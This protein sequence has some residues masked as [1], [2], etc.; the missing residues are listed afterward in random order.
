MTDFLDGLLL[1]IAIACITTA[2]SITIGFELG[3]K[4]AVEMARKKFKKERV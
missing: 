4:D 1:G 3:K 2:I